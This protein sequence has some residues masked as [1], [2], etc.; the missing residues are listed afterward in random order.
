MKELI[1]FVERLAEMDYEVVAFGDAFEEEAELIRLEDLL[2]K[3]KELGVKDIIAEYY[4]SFEF[5]D[6]YGNYIEV[7]A[8]Y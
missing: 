2:T 1:R 6:E 3:I 8:V 4:E 5:M 7:N